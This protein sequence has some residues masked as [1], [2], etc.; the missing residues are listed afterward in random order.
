MAVEKLKEA[1]ILL[2]NR[3]I[4]TAHYLAGYVLEFS[5]KAAVCRHLDIDD[6]FDTKTYVTDDRLHKGYKTHSYKDLIVLAGLYKKIEDH[7][8]NEPKFGANWVHIESSKMKWSEQ[9]R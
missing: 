8:V 5:L 7:K 3:K 9:C 2:R 4:D 6:F 1:K